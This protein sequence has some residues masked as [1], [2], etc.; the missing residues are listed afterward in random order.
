MDGLATFALMGVF[1]ICGIAPAVFRRRRSGGET[2]EARGERWFGMGISVLMAAI[3]PFFTHRP[4]LGW[5]TGVIG[6][7][8]LLYGAIGMR[9]G[10]GSHR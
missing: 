8:V 9:R 5:V 7:L 4:V 6:A 10:A 3:V 1:L 2:A